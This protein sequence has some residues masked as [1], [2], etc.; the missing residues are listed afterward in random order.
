MCAHRKLADLAAG[1]ALKP[2]LH[3]MLEKL[4]LNLVLLHSS[5]M[6]LKARAW[7]WNKH[8]LDVLPQCT[9]GPKL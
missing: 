8:V 3:V 4:N 2:S 9:R 6:C 1:S 5:R 7:A